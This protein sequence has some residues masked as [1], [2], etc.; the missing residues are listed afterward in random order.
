MRANVE[1]DEALLDQVVRL[2]E[3]RTKRA[4]INAALSEYAKLLKR[5]QLLAL[6]GKVSWQGD[7]DSLRASRPGAAE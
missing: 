7:L 5:R 4:A 2:G 3:F 6:R 1:L